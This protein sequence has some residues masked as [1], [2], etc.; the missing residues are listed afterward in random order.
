MLL[1]QDDSRAVFRPPREA[2]LVIL[3]YLVLCFWGDGDRADVVTA[4]LNFC[5][6]GNLFPRP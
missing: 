3:L 1:Q 4:S 2:K 6:V 5:Q